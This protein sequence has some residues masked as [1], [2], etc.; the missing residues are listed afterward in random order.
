MSSSLT[1]NLGVRW[2]YES[3][4]TEAQDRLVNLDVAPGFRA[5]QPVV[6]GSDGAR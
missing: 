5:V 1:V 3:P 2:E 6:A 4:I